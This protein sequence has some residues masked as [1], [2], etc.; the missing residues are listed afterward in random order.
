MTI[1]LEIKNFEL[2]V[3]ALNNACAAYGDMVRAINFGFEPQINRNKFS[4]LTDL[5]EG[6]LTKRYN[7]LVDIYKQV[8]E[9]EEKM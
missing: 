5:P 9:I 3:K 4:C 8:E 2:F 7:A 6:E 1:E